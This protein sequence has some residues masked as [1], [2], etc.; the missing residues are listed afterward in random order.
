MSQ[1]IKRGS[2]RGRRERQHE[3][4]FTLL[5]T[6]VVAG[7]LVILTAVAVTNFASVR[8]RVI[9]NNAAQEVTRYLEKTRTDSIKRHA[10]SATQS[11]VQVI[12]A[13]SYQVVMDFNGDGA[14][15]ANDV[16][17]VTL[18]TGVTF[19]VTPAL[20]AAVSYDWRGRLGAN[21]RITLQN[22]AGNQI[23]IDLSGGGDITTNSATLTLP[24]ITSTP[25]PTPSS[26]STSTPT[27]T[28]SP[29][30]PPPSGAPECYVDT[31]VTDI[32]I[33]KSGLTTG[34]VTVTQDQ[35]GKAGTITLTYDSR[36]LAVSPSNPTI[37]SE[38]NVQLAVKD[39][40]GGGKT[41]VTTL[42]IDHPCGQKIIN[43]T[44]TQ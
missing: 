28:P 43:I 19:N 26:G 35:Y 9:L 22:T 5:Q 36:E 11:R 42:T 40:K 23:N 18:P 4:G 8:Q 32:T 14:I 6:L 30:P 37:D 27:P 24:T 1:Q 15:G 25:Y 34:Y 10:A 16:R 7:V 33:R 12:S 29:S 39:V 38:G 13:T 20:P 3:R 21:N 44:V 17:N 41:Y 31:D 2:V